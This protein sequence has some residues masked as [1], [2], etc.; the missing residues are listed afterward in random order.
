[1]VSINLALEE[2]II[3]EMLA[4]HHIN[5]SAVARMEAN[6]KRIFEQYMK[7]KDMTDEDANF[8]ENIDWHPVDELPIRKE[9]IK[10][11]NIL[12]KN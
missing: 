8:C 6:K 9:F 2:H 3:K 12:Q 4:Y 5:W 10:K 1:V 11:I 7:T